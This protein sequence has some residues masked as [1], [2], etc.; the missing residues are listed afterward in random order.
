MLRDLFHARAS[1]ARTDAA[2]H[3]FEWSGRYVWG[4]I[5]DGLLRSDSLNARIC[6]ESRATASD[7]CAQALANLHYVLGRNIRHVCYVSGLPG[8][9]HARVRS[10]H[11]WLAALRAEPLLFPG[12]VAGGPMLDPVHG[13]LSWPAA[14]PLPIW[15]YWGDPALPRDESTP[16]DG[17]YTDNDSWSTNESD[18]EWQAAALYALYFAR[19]WSDYGADP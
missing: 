12:L 9:A 1:V 14:R 6:V 7:D 18:V 13:D 5:A 4:S 17:R 11:H 15:G 16:I 3:P 19:W 2:A 10:F 8:V